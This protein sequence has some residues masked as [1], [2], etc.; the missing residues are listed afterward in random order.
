MK[1]KLKIV[2]GKKDLFPYKNEDVFVNLELS[3]DSGELVNE[4]I[5]NNFNLKEQFTK[6][7]EKSLKFCVYGTCETNFSDTENVQIEISTNH[8]DP[9]YSPRFS[10]NIN[11]KT[12]HKISTIPLSKNG[13]L[14]KNIFWKKKSSYY[15]MFEISPIKYNNIG[16]NKELILKIKSNEKKVYAEIK[17]P[18]IYYNSQGTKI[19]FGTETLEIDLKGKETIVENDF[20]FL[21]D[22]HWIRADL[23]LYR[24]PKVSFL[25]SLDNEFI[26]NATSLIQNSEIEKTS[27]QVIDSLNSSINSSFSS[28]E[29]NNATV[30]E[31][32]GKFEFFAK[33]D[34]PSLYGIEEVDVY[35]KDDET[36]RNPNDDFILKTK[37]L[38]WEIGEQYKKVEVELLDDVY[39]ESTEK[40]TFGLN[41]YKYLEK[42]N[43]NSEFFLTIEDKDKPIPI[44]F[45]LSSQQIVE[46]ATTVSV[47]LFLDRPMNV[48]NQTIVVYADLVTS[49]A[50]L[51]KNFVGTDNTTVTKSSEKIEYIYE[52]DVIQKAPNDIKGGIIKRKDGGNFLDDGLILR[53]ELTYSSEKRNRK[54]DTDKKV[55]IQSIGA[56]QLR[57]VGKP[58]SYDRF[59]PNNKNLQAKLVYEIETETIGAFEKTILLTEGVSGFKFDIEI[60]NDFQYANDLNINFKLK[61]PTQNVIISNN[62]E[63]NEHTI[64]IKDSMIPNFT[65]YI[66]PGSFEKGYGMFRMN[67]FLLT[68]KKE[69]KLEIINNPNI[70]RRLIDNF[71]YEIEIVNK[72][73]KILI[74]NVSKENSPSRLSFLFEK[75]YR[76][77]DSD[78]VVARVKVESPAGFKEITIDLPSNYGL[79]KQLNQF[80]K[81][82]YEFRL[83]ARSISAPPSQFF[84]G[85]FGSSGNNSLGEEIK[86]R[87]FPEVIIKENSKGEIATQNPENSKYFLTSRIENIQSRILLSPQLT[88]NYLSIYKYNSNDTGGGV[89]VRLPASGSFIDDGFTP[90]QELI[91]SSSR[92]GQPVD[93]NIKITIEKLNE[94][95]L[96]LLNEPLSFNSQQTINNIGLKGVFIFP[97]TCKDNIT[98]NGPKVVEMNG[99]IFLSEI[100][101]DSSGGSLLSNFFGGLGTNASTYTKVLNREFTPYQINYLTCS[102]SSLNNSL[103]PIELYP[104]P[105]GI[106]GG[107]PSLSGNTSFGGDSFFRG[108]T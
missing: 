93:E 84:G 87:T 4:I 65:R 74:E 62:N 23:N 39:V 64:I 29:I 48:P 67:D 89:I 70:Q 6:E 103:I 69:L 71:E 107:N 36:I 34:Y 3:R 1:E 90:G 97:N 5:N 47:E 88:V 19:P 57:L 32:I 61:N 77:I 44:S 26:N 78:G 52:V 91:Y 102:G 99:T 49:T 2:L 30:E 94:T 51:G 20:K 80:F 42:S 17:V 72:G 11:P 96:W 59:G 106:L 66:M 63:V 56:T 37:T 31:S 73:E 81:S 104:N 35:V 68:E 25:N 105:G 55:T 15:F 58:L 101:E 40:V 12:S 43:K 41:N 86:A 27:K 14:S 9:L 8:L 85:G 24:P 95:T 53:Q 33:L 98:I 28:T 13:S 76:P 22:T 38:K 108:I 79:K 46:S 21:Y 10:T 18:F 83:K 54:I 7:R 92:F 100:F 82:K 50:V 45:A 75:G 16:K 60:L